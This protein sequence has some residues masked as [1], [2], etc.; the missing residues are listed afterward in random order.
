MICSKFGS[1]QG[2]WPLVMGCLLC[3]GIWAE[4]H[5]LAT[6]QIIPS[7][8]EEFIGDCAWKDNEHV[9]RRKTPLTDC[10]HTY[11]GSGS[12][13][14][15]S[16]GQLPLTL[17]Y[18]HTFCADRFLLNVLRKKRRKKKGNKLCPSEALNTGKDEGWTKNVGWI[19]QLDSH[20]T[21]DWEWN[22]ERHPT[23]T[24]HLGNSPWVISRCIKHAGQRATDT[25]LRV[26]H[27]GTTENMS[28]WA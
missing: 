17:S 26:H 24:I 23:N 7:R 6:S 22:G 10:N 15:D 27:M 2:W 3:T 8:I 14:K 20:H 18:R 1:K 25:Y 9:Q 19:L 28:T 21:S 13:W 5:L 12:Y 4:K 11:C 16:S